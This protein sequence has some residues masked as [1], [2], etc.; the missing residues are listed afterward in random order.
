M[1]ARVGEAD[2]ARLFH[3]FD[4][5][6]ALAAAASAAVAVVAACGDGKVLEL[7][8]V[9]PHVVHVEQPAFARDVVRAAHVDVL[10]L[11]TRAHAL[12]VVAQVLEGVVGELIKARADDEPAQAA[13]AEQKRVHHLVREERGLRPHAVNV[14]LVRVRAERGWS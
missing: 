1:R 7:G 11:Q 4:R 9:V 10:E 8:Q 3:L 12:L 13:V 2:A 5:R 14:D 6:Q